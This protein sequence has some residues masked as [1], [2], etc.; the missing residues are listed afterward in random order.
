MGGKLLYIRL[1]AQCAAAEDRFEGAA[2]L[3]SRVEA[4]SNAADSERV[5]LKKD[6]ATLSRT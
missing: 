4:V 5:V 1:A 2:D 6:K 3:T